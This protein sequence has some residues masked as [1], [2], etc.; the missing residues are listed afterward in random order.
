MLQKLTKVYIVTRTLKKLFFPSDIPFSMV[1]E[2]T[3]LYQ[4]VIN[5]VS[6]LSMQSMTNRGLKILG[7][8][9]ISH[10]LLIEHRR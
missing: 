3:R 2:A 7:R 4:G 10:R 9:S 5:V 8:L 6:D 1:F